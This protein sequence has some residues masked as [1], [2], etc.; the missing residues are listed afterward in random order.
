MTLP[1]LNLLELEGVTV[2][3]G[4]QAV[5]SGLNLTLRRGAFTGLM[6]ANGSGK[7]TLLR[8]ILGIQPPLAGRVRFQGANGRPPILGYVPQREAL[9]AAF[10]VSGIEVVLMGAC[11]RVGA[12]RFYPRAEKAWARQ[13]LRDV[14]AADLAHHRF[15][16]LSGGQKQRVLMARALATRPDLLILDEPTTG[17]DAGTTR[18]ILELLRRLHGERGLT[19]LMVNHD[20]PA[21]RRY[22]NDV[23]W[24]HEGRLLRGPVSELLRREKVEEF[25][26][27]SLA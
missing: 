18:A 5:L 15:S 14:E 4:R 16:E 10:L 23:I 25:L 7:S 17:I 9:D 24:I 13:C 19:V 26:G 22:V 11:G 27:P 8:T 3:Y 6:G 20:L 2:G 1:E 12:G 21:M